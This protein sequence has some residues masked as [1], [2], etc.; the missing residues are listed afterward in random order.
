[1]TFLFSD[2]FVRQHRKLLLLP[3][4]SLPP[5]HPT[6][7]RRQRRSPHTNRPAPTLDSAYMQSFDNPP[8]WDLPH[9]SS[10]SQFADD[11]FLALLQK[12]FP[13]ESV[14]ANNHSSGYQDG[15]N[16][17][18]I[19][20]Y[21]LANMTPPSEDS[22]PSSPNMMDSP[23]NDETTDPALKRKASDISIEGG[24]SQKAQHTGNILLST[25][26]GFESYVAYHQ[27]TTKNRPQ[28]PGASPLALPDL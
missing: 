3:T 8:L 18:N 10:F 21:S 28:L 19:S 25:F 11:E 27:Q 17:Q 14:S 22:S 5:C 6:S 13:T 9:A 12:Q 1:V 24:P 4:P 16:P 2:C 23:V 20:R 7:P 26:I 15:V